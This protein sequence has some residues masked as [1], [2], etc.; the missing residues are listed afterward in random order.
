MYGSYADDTYYFNLG[1]GSDRIIETSNGESYSNIDP[2]HDRLVFGAGITSSMLAVSAMVMIY[3]LKVRA[4]GDTILIERWYQEPTNHFKL[5]QFVF[6][7]GAVLTR[8]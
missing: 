3:L 2:S 7:D 6:D 5:N 1:D 4:S 8:C